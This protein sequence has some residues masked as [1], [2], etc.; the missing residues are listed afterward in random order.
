MSAEHRNLAFEQRIGQNTSVSAAY[1]ATQGSGLYMFDDANFT[2][3]YPQASRPDPRFTD[4]RIMGN[5]GF[6]RYNALQVYGRRRF[7]QGFTFTAAYTYSAYR[8]ITSNDTGPAIP[9]LINTGASAAAGFQIGPSIPR[10]LDSEYGRNE[11]DAPHVL[12]VSH[13]WEIPVGKGR[14]LLANLPRGLDTVVGGWTLSGIVSARSG[15]VFDVQ[16]GQD[17]ND[18]GALVDRPALAGAAKLG[19]LRQTQNLDKTQWLLPLADARNLLVVPANV[20]NP[21]APV[22]RNSF[23]AP[24]LINY[25]LSLNKGF[26]ITERFTL[27]LDANFFNIFNRAQF[28]APVSI[29]TSPFFG[30]IQATSPNAVP[31]Q[32]QFGIKLNF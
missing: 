4:Q 18:D 24:S 1:V 22:R 25:D 12:A 17:V 20:T 8:D 3:A 13:L 23:R 29:L 26:R 15:N 16:L 10:P 31:R 27:G 5:L 14:S 28:R 9:T 32:I 21:F 19:D 30:Q 7:A 11:S 2:G 6:S